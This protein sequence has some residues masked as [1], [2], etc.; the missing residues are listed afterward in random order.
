MLSTTSC[1]V[2]NVHGFNG[3]ARRNI[4]REF[5]VQQRATVV[6]LQETKLSVIYNALTIETLG[7]LFDYAFDTASWALHGIWMPME[8]LAISHPRVG[9][10]ENSAK[11]P[12]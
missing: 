9:K 12:S 8:E 11:Q 7:S 5:L 2:W 10:H 4:V 3:R 1:F 6:C